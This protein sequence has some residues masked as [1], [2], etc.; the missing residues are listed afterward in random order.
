MRRSI[1]QLSLVLGLLSPLCSYAGAFGEGRIEKLR[2]F[3]D[4]FAED[5]CMNASDGEIVI[6]RGLW[7]SIVKALM[8]EWDL[9]YEKSKRV[10]TIIMKSSYSKCSAFFPPGFFKE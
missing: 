4:Y 2:N 9:D 3:I 5:I 1:L 10:S 8:E 6:D 7:F